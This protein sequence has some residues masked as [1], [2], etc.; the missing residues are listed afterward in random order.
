M[1]QDLVIYAT[2]CTYAAM[3]LTDLFKKY[4]TDEYTGIVALF[5]TMFGAVV[6]DLGL[7]RTLGFEYTNTVYA[8]YFDV[9]LT[10][11]AM[12]KGANFLNDIRDLKSKVVYI[13]DIDGT[14][15]ETAEAEE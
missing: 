2:V 4:V 8:H 12:S 15:E 6:F 5:F 3:V 1:I 14:G 11:V 10:G 7:I 9:I 13:S